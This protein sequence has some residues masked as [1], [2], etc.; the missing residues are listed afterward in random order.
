MQDDF[1]SQLI[2]REGIDRLLEYS[3]INEVIQTGS[4]IENLVYDELGKE[5]LALH[6]E[7]F[8]KT[9]I[10]DINKYKNGQPISFSNTPRVLSYAQILRERFPSIHV[11]SPEEVI[12]YWGVIP[13]KDS[14][15][16]DTNSIVVYPKEGCNEDLRQRVLGII[17]KK[18][19]IPLVVSGLGVERADNNY[20]FR[21]IGT[22]FTEAR[23]APY[24]RQEGRVRFNGKEKELV[25][26]E[27]GVRV[28]TAESGLRGLYRCGSDWLLAGDSRLFY[29]CEPGRV[30]V[31]CV[32]NH[33]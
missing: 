9:K 3:E 4:I 11:L 30:Q 8:K 27:E 6:N 18:N 2:E 29:S 10:E 21:F 19:K 32:N 26:S 7:K 17:G 5:V 15:Y 16:A 14:T 28:W 1:Y 20:G 31:V 24:L 33:K 13:E 12:K 22:D 23:E 25:S